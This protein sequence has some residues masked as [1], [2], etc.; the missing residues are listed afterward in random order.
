MCESRIP[1]TGWLGGMLLLLAVLAG[2]GGN[3]NDREQPIMTPPPQ[4]DLVWDQG[5]WDELNWQ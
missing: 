2:C 1:R 4:T 3:H 5:N